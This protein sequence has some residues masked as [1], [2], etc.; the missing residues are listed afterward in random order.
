[1][2]WAE[3]GSTRGQA[4]RRIA[5]I[6]APFEAA[7]CVASTTKVTMDTIMWPAHSSGMLSQNVVP[8]AKV[9]RLQDEIRTKARFDELS[10]RIKQF[11]RA[12]LLPLTAGYG[13]TGA[14]KSRAYLSVATPR[15]RD[16]A[17]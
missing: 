4:G 16:P 15:P 12:T 14:G 2:E 10:S 1:V 5:L 6:L 13:K 11:D 3:R 9:G 17:K 8:Q 7:N